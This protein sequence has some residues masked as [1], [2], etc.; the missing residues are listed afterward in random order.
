MSTH[1]MTAGTY[2][3]QHYKIM[4]ESITINKHAFHLAAHVQRTRTRTRTRPLYRSLSKHVVLWLIGSS[5][6]QIPSS[7]SQCALN[8]QLQ[9]NVMVYNHVFIYA[10]RTTHIPIDIVNEHKQSELYS[11]SFM[12]CISMA[13]MTYPCK[14]EYTCSY[15]CSAWTERMTFVL[16]IYSVFHFSH[17]L[18]EKIPYLHERVIIRWQ[19][20]GIL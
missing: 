3:K 12:H 16:C 9:W 1:E 11:L 8:M 17:E 5:R 2:I 20:G 10:I 18:V 7:C 6:G 14:L 13:S 15:S 19:W 4:L